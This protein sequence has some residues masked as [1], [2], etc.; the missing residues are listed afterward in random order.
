MKKHIIALALSLICINTTLCEV[1]APR[2]LCLDNEYTQEFAVGFAAGAA[3][4]FSVECLRNH[5]LP[6]MTSWNL[7]RHYGICRDQ[8]TGEAKV[9]T[10]LLIAAAYAN[11]RNNTDWKKL[12]AR[13]LGVILGACAASFTTKR[14]TQAS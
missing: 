3:A 14:I 4:G 13:L 5:I 1:E 10:A 11:N 9:A 12:S 8:L 7:Y 6:D 2:A